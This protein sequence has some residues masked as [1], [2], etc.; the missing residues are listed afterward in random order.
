MATARGKAEMADECA[1]QARDDFEL[2]R[3]TAKQFAP[4]FTQPSKSIYA[5]VT[6][7]I[8]FRVHLLTCFMSFLWDTPEPGNCE[9]LPPSRL[10]HR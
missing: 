3:E 7:R 6:S 5:I 8:P 4:E 9:P 10:A 1:D 2:A